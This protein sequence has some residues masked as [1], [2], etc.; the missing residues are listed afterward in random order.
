[1][2][3]NWAQKGSLG[4]F[5]LKNGFNGV[6]SLEAQPLPAGFQATVGIDAEDSTRH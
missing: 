2:G 4:I 6:Q 5:T 3:L 1:M